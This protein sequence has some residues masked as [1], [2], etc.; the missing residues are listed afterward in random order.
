MH[1]LKYIYNSP[2]I[3]CDVRHLQLIPDLTFLEI[4]PASRVWGDFEE[5]KRGTL[6]MQG[7][8]FGPHPVTVSNS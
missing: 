3:R 2:G 1:G 7:K 5:S 6:A 4:D 8:E